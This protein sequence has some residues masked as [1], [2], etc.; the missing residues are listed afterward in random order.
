[1]G[2]GDGGGPV[3]SEALTEL[4]VVAKTL[5]QDCRFHGVVSNTSM[6]KWLKH[7]K[8]VKA[9][10]LLSALQKMCTHQVLEEVPIGP[11]SHPSQDGDGEAPRVR[12]GGHRVMKVKKK[13]L[14]D[15]RA[16]TR[17]M[18]Y[19]QKLGISTDGFD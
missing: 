19:L 11:E 17:A 16:S 2:G 1:M 12:R 6:R 14:A 9:E 4:D 7:K 5:L 13:L 10:N 8:G 18:P 15:I 3:S